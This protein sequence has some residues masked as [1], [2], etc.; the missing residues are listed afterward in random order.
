MR[1]SLERLSTRI[2][3]FINLL[4]VKGR[5]AATPLLPNVS[6][7]THTKIQLLAT[8]WINRPVNNYLASLFA[9]QDDICKSVYM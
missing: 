3:K 5:A 8:P 9:L 4:E 2:E 6:T 1:Q 7:H